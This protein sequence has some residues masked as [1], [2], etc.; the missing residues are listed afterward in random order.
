MGLR[1]DALRWLFSRPATRRYPKEKPELPENFRGLPR[2]DKKKCIGCGI[3]VRECPAETIGVIEKK[4]DINYLNCITCG[5][6]VRV[7]PVN[8]IEQ[9]RVYE[10]V[11]KD[12]GRL[13]KF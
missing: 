7:C 6:C 11:S 4:A 8:A 5:V 9:T 13:S 3:C 1:I 12:K 10:R 2:I